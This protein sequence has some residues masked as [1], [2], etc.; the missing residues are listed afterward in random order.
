MY[1]KITDLGS[2]INKISESLK[3]KGDV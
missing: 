1:G 2:G 3:K